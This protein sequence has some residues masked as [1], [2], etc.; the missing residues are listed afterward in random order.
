M[1][2][3]A[4]KTSVL[5][6]GVKSLAVVG[7]RLV[8]LA[9]DERLDDDREVIGDIATAMTNVRTE[10]TAVSRKLDVVQREAKEREYERDVARQQARD[11]EARQ[12]RAAADGRTTMQL[13]AAGCV[14]VCLATGFAARWWYAPASVAA[15]VE[16]RAPV[17]AQPVP[18]VAVAPIV[19]GAV[20]TST[21]GVITPGATATPQATG[22][23]ACAFGY[24]RQD[25]LICPQDV[26]GVTV[27]H[28]STKTVR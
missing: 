18:P 11:A 10:V 27:Q 15:V 17:F 19:G 6:A 1:T 2:D 4:V 13:M 12:K 3:A 14:V 9:T 21:S 26:R 20:A 28:R 5:E 24:G 23:Y 16:Q 8:K 7:D 22:D 25:G